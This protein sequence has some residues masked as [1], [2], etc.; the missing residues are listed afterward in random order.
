MIVSG[1]RRSGA[2]GVAAAAHPAR[3][4]DGVRGA[5]AGARPRLHRLRQRRAA[6][7]I[8]LDYCLYLL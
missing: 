8:I 4:H 2:R 3:L 5:G 1:V 7:G 6:Q